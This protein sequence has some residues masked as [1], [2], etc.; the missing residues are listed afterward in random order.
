MPIYFAACKVPTYLLNWKTWTW[1]QLET[2]SISKYQNTLFFVSTK[3][4]AMH[5]TQDTGHVAPTY[6]PTNPMV[7]GSNDSFTRYRTT[8]SISHIKRL[9][10]FCF[11]RSSSIT[12]LDSFG[13]FANS[14]ITSPVW[15]EVGMKSNQP[16][17]LQKLPISSQSKFLHKIYLYLKRPN[18][19]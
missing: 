4:E 11:R 8:F 14:L 3:V 10:K 7:V 18:I 9:V 16:S 19:H 12:K 1:I 6:V 17:C 5:A 2:F 15:P 13:Q